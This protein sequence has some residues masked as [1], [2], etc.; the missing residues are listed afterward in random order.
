MSHSVDRPL[1]VAYVVSY[2]HPFASG[3]ERQALAQGIELARRGHDVRVITRSVPGYPIHDEEYHG[4]Q[5]HRW[6]RTWNRGPL[7][8]LSFVAGVVHALRRL[9]SRIDVI[10]THQG[11]WEA[12]ATGLARPG[13]TGVPT[14]VQPAASGYYGEAD[15]LQRTRG[16]AVLRRLILRNTAFA[17]ISAEIERQWLNLGVPPE[18]MFR[19]ASGVDTEHFHPG[20][21]AV[22]AE[23]LPRPRVLF[24]GR[25][26]PQKNLPLL[27]EAWVLVARQTP[28]NLI[29]V[30]PGTE[31][32]SL[33]ALAQRLGIAERVQFT[34]AVPDPADH[35]RAADLFVL[36]SVAEGMSN[37]LLEAMATALPCVV[38]GIGGNTDLISD[39][40]TGRLVS[41]P[42]S[43]GW[44]AILIELLTNPDEARRLGTAARQ[45]VE[46]EFSLHVMIDRYLE[47]YRSLIQRCRSI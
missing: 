46:R 44:A 16:S 7:F 8:A 27:L 20:S 34:G 28:A 6:V 40:Q 24:T 26:H 14:L 17:A 1:R 9:G 12:V 39:Q 11:L 18:S 31:R 43:A 45:R 3:A 13:L 37:S 5:I 22:D 36:S 32:E 21:S 42:D 10:H 33:A 4:I 38:S 23:L 19:M 41:A 47:L 2:F 15:E 30:G 29:L 25:M 35:L